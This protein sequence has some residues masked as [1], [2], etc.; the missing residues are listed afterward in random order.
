MGLVLRLVIQFM[1]V[2][3]TTA[4][5]YISTPTST[6][7][8]TESHLPQ[9]E[10]SFLF[11]KPITPKQ[12]S[13]TETVSVTTEIKP[14]TNIE[15]KK[16]LVVEQRPAPIQKPIV[17][18]VIK[19]EPEPIVRQKPQNSVEDAVV[20]I[21]C[22]KKVGNALISTTGTGVLVSDNGTILTNAHVAI[23]VLKAEVLDDRSCTIRTS[24]A[25]GS[26]FKTSLLYIPSLWIQNNKEF[27]NGARVKSTG[28]NDFA[29]IKAETKNSLPYIP[30]AHGVIQKN[31]SVITV[32]Y[33][34]GNLPSFSPFTKLF[35][36]RDIV[37]VTGT[38]SFGETTA[39]I[40]STSA[41]A[42]GYEGSSGGAVANENGELGA[43]IVSV[44]GQSI[45]ALTI[46]Y[47]Q[48]LF[49][50]ETNLDLET[51][52]E[53]PIKYKNDFK[54]IYSASQDALRDALN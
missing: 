50:K 19:S 13:S 6:P 9:D 54:D 32:G 49:K 17:N 26:N 27:I 10:L 11:E 43:L 45:N 14:E 20:N 2:G 38:Y 46:P 35:Q 52:I 21:L 30:F 47:I 29:L 44:N 41:S 39:D 18:E 12:A 28:A 22:T 40:I 25:G 42:T 51:Y 7:V 48:S 5:T 8:R 23:E 4:V 33:P 37:R 15:T 36:V 34:A 16:K 24:I 3:L 31:D 1:V 53:N